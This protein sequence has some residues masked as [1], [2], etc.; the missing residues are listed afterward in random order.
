MRPEA[1]FLCDGLILKSLKLVNEFRPTFSLVS[2]LRDEQHEWL[3][4]S[5]SYHHASGLP[6]RKNPPVGPSSGRVAAHTIPIAP[7]STGRP[8]APPIS[9]ATHPGQTEFTKMLLSRSSPASVLVSAF[10]PAFV[11]W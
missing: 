1:N 9:V 4:Q 8:P 3:K 11:T 7:S 5:G 6:S 2:E 10:S